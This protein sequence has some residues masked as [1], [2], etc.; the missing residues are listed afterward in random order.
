MEKFKNQMFS[1]EQENALHVYQAQE[2]YVAIKCGQQT[3]SGVNRQRE[4]LTFSLTFTRKW[5]TLF[6]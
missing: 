6:I 1:L 2:L 4:N 5:N 3:H